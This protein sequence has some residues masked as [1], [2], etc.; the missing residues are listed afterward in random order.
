MDEKFEQQCDVP[1]NR[2]KPVKEVWK[3]LIT[4]KLAKSGPKRTRGRNKVGLGRK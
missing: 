4:I 3:F 1:L 2:L